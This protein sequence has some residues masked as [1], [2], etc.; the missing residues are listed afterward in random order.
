MSS[1]SDSLVIGAGVL[2]LSTASVLG[3]RGARVTVIDPGGPNASA[4]AAGMIAPAMEAL[5]DFRTTGRD[6]SDLF[7]A[8]AT[9][10]PDFAGARAI[11]LH[12]EGTQWC[13]SDPHGVHAT[14]IRFGFQARLDGSTVHIAGERRIDAVDALAALSVSTG[15]TRRHG[16]VAGLARN[17][18]GW[19]V[20]L[21][22]GERVHTRSVVVASGAVTSL[23]G[24]PALAAALARVSPIKGQIANLP[25]RLFDHVVRGDAGYVAPATG[26]VVV[27]ATMQPGLS[28]LT[29]D[30]VAGAAL[31]S[32]CMTMIG[33]AEPGELVWRVGLRGASPDGLPMAG[34]IEDGLYVALAPRRNGWLMG[35]LVGEVVAD[36]IAGLPS[37]AWAA[38]LDPLRFER[39]AGPIGHS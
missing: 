28:D 11:V 20:T 32:A 4:I 13:G 29:P 33:E 27:G 34:V 7:R 2:G 12:D 37:G 39:A 26:G 5:S 24:P 16:Q 31:A 30:P 1:S 19:T 6:N 15:V 14:L 18:S 23:A 21:Q 9:L 36:A 25:H 22:D 8:A 35:P 38:Q 3:A 17:S 10:W